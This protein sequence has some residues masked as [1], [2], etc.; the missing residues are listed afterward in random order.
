MGGLL[1]LFRLVEVFSGVGSFQLYGALQLQTL[2]YCRQA[3]PPGLLWQLQL[4]LGPLLI[5]GPPLARAPVLYFFY[6]LHQG[7]GVV[8]IIQN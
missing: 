7:D 5:R 4:Q 6:F 1:G 3:P 2:D 8:Q